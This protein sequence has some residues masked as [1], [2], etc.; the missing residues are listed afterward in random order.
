MYTKLAPVQVLKLMVEEKKKENKKK[1]KTD[2]PASR[3]HQGYAQ[4]RFQATEPVEGGDELT[5]ALLLAPF[6]PLKLPLHCLPYLHQ[7][8]P[9]AISGISYIV[10]SNTTT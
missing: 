1:E 8:V 5:W 6:L 4:V 10:H 7:Q 9:I 2:K 3:C